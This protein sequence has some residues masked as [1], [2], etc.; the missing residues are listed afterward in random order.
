MPDDRERPNCC[1]QL[2]GHGPRAHAHVGVGGF[3]AR[4][5]LVGHLV[6]IDEGIA[7]PMPS[8]PVWADCRRR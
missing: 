8:A 7:K 6:T 3:A 4:D 2:L 1:L 5:D